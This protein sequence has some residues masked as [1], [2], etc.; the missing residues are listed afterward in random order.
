MSS[1]PEETEAVEPTP[2]PVTLEVQGV[3]VAVTAEVDD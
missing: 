3:T 2:P 1:E